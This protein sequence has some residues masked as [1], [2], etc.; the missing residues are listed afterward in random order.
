MTDVAEK[1]VVREY[2]KSI[3]KQKQNRFEENKGKK[4]RR[5]NKNTT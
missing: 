3:D 4:S 5:K 1:E 2:N